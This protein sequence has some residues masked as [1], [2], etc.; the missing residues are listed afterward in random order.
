MTARQYRIQLDGV[1]GDRFD[2]WFTGFRLEQAPTG[3]V[4]VGTCVDESAL[5]GVFDQV[6]ALGLGLLTVESSPIGD[7]RAGR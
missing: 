6:E 1:L 4:L 5:F 2:T 3:T 7:E